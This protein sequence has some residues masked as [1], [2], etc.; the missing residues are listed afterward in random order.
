MSP[1]PGRDA[2]QPERTALAWQRTAI[3]AMVVLVPLVLVSLRIGQA[4]LAALG[5]LA[6][7]A[8]VALVASVRRRFVQL[9]DDDVGY[10]PYPPML[11][12]ALVTVVGA[13][14]G[15]TLGLFLWLH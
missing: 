7:G 4:V 12:V 9:G 6:M 14:G 1:I 10:S 8:S 13:V 15:A 5:A 2:L 11:R 3:T